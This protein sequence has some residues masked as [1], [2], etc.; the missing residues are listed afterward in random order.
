[1]K[2]SIVSLFILI[3]FFSTGLFAQ[4]MAPGTPPGQA[5]PGD[6]AIGGNAP[7]GSGIFILLSLGVAYTGKKIYNL[8]K[9]EKEE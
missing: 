5:Q 9:E 2:K 1:M 7:V 6:K 3:F 4:F 8:N